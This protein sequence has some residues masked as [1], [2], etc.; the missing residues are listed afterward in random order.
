MNLSL[1][2][3]DIVVS[4][5]RTSGK[6][7]IGNYFGAIANFV[8]LQD[9]CENI[10]CFLADLHT[11][12]THTDPKELKESTKL[13]LAIYLGCGLNPDKA[14]I[15]IQSHLKEISELY[16]YLN[17]FSYVGELER[18]TTFKEK[19]QKHADNINAGLLTYPVLMAADVLIHKGTK[20]PI[21]K[22]QT[23]H[24]EMM[25]N[26]GNRFNYKYNCQIFPEPMAYNFGEELLKVPS[27]GGSGK[28]DKSGPDDY[29]IF[30]T[31]D[32]KAIEK[33]IKRAV[34]DTG[35]TEPNSEKPESIRNL[36]DIMK[37]VSAP[38]AIENFDIAYNNCSI[39]YGDMKKQIAEDMIAFL[40][41]IREKIDYY[42]HNENILNQAA[43]KGLANAQISAAK[44]MNEVR[45][46]MGFTR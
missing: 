31:D 14:N 39:R 13:T 1:K 22:D 6:L 17:M 33:K 38:D 5:V 9:Q 15:Y 21:G 18:T 28:M 37:L 32:D 7:T 4:G 30:L 10:F 35:P 43:E 23:Q 34:T 26:F 19:I 16:L 36:F 3:T 45:A 27:L 46:A 2:T 41:P 20:V 11:L 42:Y 29:A 44:T 8:K 40:S 24:L 12:T 25:R